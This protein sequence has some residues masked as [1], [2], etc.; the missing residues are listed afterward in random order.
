VAHAYNTNYLGAWIGRILVWGK[1]R[2]IAYKTPISKNNQN[3]NELKG[4]SKSRAHALQVQSTEFKSQSHQNKHKQ[5]TQI[6][7]QR[8]STKYIT[9][10]FQNY[11]L[12]EKAKKTEKSPLMGEI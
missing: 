3:K 12:Y 2:Q 1:P 4:S 9:K 11:Q 7:I 8:Y 10:A 5:K 6:Q